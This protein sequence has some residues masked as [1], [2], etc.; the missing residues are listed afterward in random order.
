MFYHCH[1]LFSLVI[2]IKE[3]EEVT[4]N[5]LLCSPEK[6]AHR[7]RSTGTSLVIATHTPSSEP[8][9]RT[10]EMLQLSHSQSRLLQRGRDTDVERGKKGVGARGS[11]GARVGTGAIGSGSLWHSAG[12]TTA[13]ARPGPPLTFRHVLV[14]SPLHLGKA[15]LEIVAAATASTSCHP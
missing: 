1:Y 4:V 5:S 13:E 14:D 12:C 11:D 10:G 8:R 2:R 7:T 6:K 3:Q 9:A 15:P